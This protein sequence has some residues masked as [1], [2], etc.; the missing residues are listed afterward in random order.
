[1]AIVKQY[2]DGNCKVTFCDDYYVK[3]KDE[4]TNLLSTAA[5]IYA[6]ARAKRLLSEYEK[7]NEAN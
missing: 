4:V 2:M 3:T 6:N 1:M 7:T 5:E